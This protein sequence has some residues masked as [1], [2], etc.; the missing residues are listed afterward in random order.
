MKNVIV[1]GG[2]GFIGGHLAKKL[3]EQGNHVRI[4]DLKKHEYFFQDEICDEFIV[5]DLTDP[6]V[7]EL[8]I[9]EGVDEVYQLAADMGG[10]MYIF[11]GQHDADV[12]YNSATINLNVVRECVK[13]KVGKV[14][15]SS[16]ACMYPEHNQLDPENPNCE[17]S[18][19]YPANPD[20]EYGWEK[21]F[22]ERLFLAHQKNYGLDVKIARFHNIY[23]P[24]G[25]WNGGREKAPAAMCRKVV[26]AKDGDEIEVW[27][28]GN[29]T[30]SFLFVD[31][32]VRA[33]LEL[34]ESKFSGPVNIGSEEMVSINKLA[35]IAISVSGK[36]LSIKNL[37]GEEFR[38]KYGF[39]CPL[40]VKGRNS[41]NKLYRENL[42]SDV[43]YPLDLG[44]K[45]T[46]N[47]IKSEVDNIEK[48]TKWIYE[49]P[50]GK[51]VYKRKPSEV[52]RIKIK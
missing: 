27:G 29:Q 50:D 22:S 9:G 52:E 1:L 13:K 41:D 48:E 14:F 7:V 40:G 35:E 17:E 34:M 6:K 44:I 33:V 38:K 23:G 31:E 46:Y 24:Q 5:G 21:L 20:S 28:D 49:S 37:E 11:T 32:C 18:S 51:I 4:C 8:V 10:A 16:S 30:R 47:W 15:Y 45:M 3:K 42:G 26:E 43:F 36:N 25:T 19:A 2:G 12:M 39:K